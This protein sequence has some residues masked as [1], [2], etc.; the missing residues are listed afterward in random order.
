MN[1]ASRGIAA[2]FLSFMTFA[3]MALFFSAV[4]D[5]PQVQRVIVEAA[6]ALALI[7]ILFL[8]FFFGVLPEKKEMKNRDRRS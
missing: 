7:G 3:G 6:L 2:L 5:N 4:Q 1:T 8:L